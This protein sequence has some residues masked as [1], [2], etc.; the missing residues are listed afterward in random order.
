MGFLTNERNDH[1]K[2]SRLETESMTSVS[3]SVAEGTAPGFSL[4]GNQSIS[5]ETLAP[6]AFPPSSADA[7]VCFLSGSFGMSA[8]WSLEEAGCL[9]PLPASPPQPT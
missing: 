6:W 1:W 9:F 4:R 7:A 3:T 8:D 5:V 2:R